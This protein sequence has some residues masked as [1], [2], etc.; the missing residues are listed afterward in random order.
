MTNQ[1]SAQEDNRRIDDC[2]AIWRDLVNICSRR[3]E[4]LE[5]GGGSHST[6][7]TLTVAV[8]QRRVMV[9]EIGAECD[10]H[11]WWRTNSTVQT[12]AVWTAP[13]RIGKTC[14]Q[15]HEAVKRIDE[16]KTCVPPC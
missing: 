15:V 8:G 11:K 10:A 1:C 4:A 3:P 13:L 6:A 14:M 12:A 2:T 16:W 7:C 9:A 5:E